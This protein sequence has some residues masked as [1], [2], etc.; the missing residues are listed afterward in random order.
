MSTYDPAESIDALFQYG[1]CTVTRTIMIDSDTSD[2][3]DDPGPELNH[4][5]AARAL[6]GLHVLE[7]MG[8]GPISVLI[9]CPGG[10]TTDG[11]AIFDRLLE[12]RESGIHVVTQAIGTAQ[13][14]G[15]ILLQAGTTRQCYPNTTLMLHDGTV[16]A[17]G[18]IRNVER[19]MASE[20]ME[21]QRS[22]RLLAERNTAGHDAAYFRR[23]LAYD[24]YLTPEE[25]LAE[26]LIDEIIGR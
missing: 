8:K 26:G 4:K 3:E 11:M 5:T 14:M 2:D 1:L 13:S 7:T 24:W 25:A 20:N 18:T 6:R 15:A 16:G 10:S 21:R 22:Y 12:L 17:S 19:Q 23:K 9:N